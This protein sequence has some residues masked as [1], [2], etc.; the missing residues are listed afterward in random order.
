MTGLILCLTILIVV[1]VEKFTEGAWLTLLITG[2]LIAGCYAIRRHYHDV[3]ARLGK[4]TEILSDIPTSGTP[5]VAKP[6][7]PAAPT[8]VLLV[9]GY[10]GLGIHSFLAIT[11]QFAGFYRQFVFT[12]VAVIDSGAFKGSE[13]IAHLES[14]VREGLEKYADFARRLGLP[15]EIRMSTGTDVIDEAEALCK[16]IARDYPR[17]AFFGGKL[18]FQRDKWYHRLLHNETAHAIQQR[19]EWEGLPMMV[20]PIRVRT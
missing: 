4:L 12:S 5:P 2:A 13:E 6:L 18:V 7:D 16:Q 10:N 17:A 1:I 14:S 9:A 20:M 3:Y 11:R 15:A 19:I 8:A